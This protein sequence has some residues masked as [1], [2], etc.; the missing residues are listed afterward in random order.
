MIVEEESGGEEDLDGEPVYSILDEQIQDKA[1]LTLPK[2]LCICKVF[3]IGKILLS[4][5]FFHLI[6][7]K[8]LASL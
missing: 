3:F 6:I 4:K 7:L 1:R 5:N 8:F 2:M